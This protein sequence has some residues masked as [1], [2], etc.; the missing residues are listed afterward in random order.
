MDKPKFSTF[1]LFGQRGSLLTGV[2]TVL[3]IG[4]DF[5]DF[6]YSQSNEEADA[7]AIAN[8][9]GVIGQELARAIE[10]VKKEKSKQLSLNF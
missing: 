5:F 4:G 6:N 10:V 3:N 2:A 1:Y 7:K 9:W 8:D